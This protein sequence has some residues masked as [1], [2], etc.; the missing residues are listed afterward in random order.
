VTAQAT[1]T[2]GR[3]RSSEA[4]AAIVRATL[5]TLVEEGYR[6]L[7]VERVARR[8]G[9]GKATI[10]RRHKTKQDLVKAAV[11]HLHA[12]LAV[13]EDMGS[14][15]SE[16]AAVAAQVASTGAER[17]TL[18]F[19]P[20]MMAEASG[21]PEVHAIFHE[22]LV[23]PR[24]RVLRVIIERAQ[25][26]GEVRPEVDPDVAIDLIAGPMIYRLLLGGLTMP[27]L[28]AR[29]DAVLTTAIEGLRTR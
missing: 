13:P 10:Y 24:R 27:E 6:G 7:S 1:P 9:V 16:F 26:R 21:D 25:A 12:D 8:A 15:R 17:G 11:Q 22:H 4:D 2:R 14:L 18:T 20:R 29:S 5:E 3:P 19:M 28:A 23:M